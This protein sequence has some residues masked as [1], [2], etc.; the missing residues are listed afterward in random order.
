MRTKV[1][2]L[3][4][5]CIVL[6][7]LPIILAG[8][9][10]WELALLGATLFFL[11]YFLL[12]FSKALRQNVKYLEAFVFSSYFIVFVGCWLFFCMFWLLP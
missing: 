2:R 4:A 5:I 8:R 10:Q 9:G 6:F 7:G 12:P 3:L 11:A 1:D